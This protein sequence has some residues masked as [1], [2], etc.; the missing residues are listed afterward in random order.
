MNSHP[1]LVSPPSQENVVEQRANIAAAEEKIDKIVD[2]SRLRGIPK[3]YAKRLPEMSMKQ[4]S[5]DEIARQLGTS[6]A[7][8]RSARKRFTDLLR[9]KGHIV[10]DE[11]D[12]D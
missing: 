4:N 7:N 11:L 12:E 5:T 3:L 1:L 10:E 6:K 2:G 9:G 8:I